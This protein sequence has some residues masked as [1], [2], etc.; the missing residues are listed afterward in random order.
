MSNKRIQ[1]LLAGQKE[2]S[3]DRKQAPVQNWA[4]TQPARQIE[5][6]N[7]SCDKE[8]G[9][10]NRAQEGAFESQAS[11]YRYNARRCH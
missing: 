6:R 10:R 3:L 8:D 1:I 7:D 9:G 4:D 5:L 2:E 11:L